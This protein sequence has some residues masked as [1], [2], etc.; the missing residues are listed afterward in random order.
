PQGGGGRAARAAGRGDLCGP[1]S[2]RGRGVVARALDAPA[3]TPP[4]RRPWYL[5]YTAWR[6]WAGPRRRAPP[7]PPPPAPACC[8]PGWWPPPAPFPILPVPPAPPY[9][10]DKTARGTVYHPA[11]P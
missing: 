9:K 10:A 2:G 1:Q 11:R 7:P 3:M 8:V 4:R 5:W 6:P